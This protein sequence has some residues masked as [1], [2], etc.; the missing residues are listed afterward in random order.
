[1]KLRVDLSST[2]SLIGSVLKWL[3]LPLLA[4]LILSI[5]HGTI[6]APF[7]FTIIMTLTAGFGLEQLESEPELQIRE[8]FLVVSLSWLLIAIVGAL[9]FYLSGTGTLASPINAFF[10]S[11]S[12]FTTT[13]S[14]IL[15]E[16]SERVHSR[17]LLLW[18]Q[19]IQWL[20]GMGIIVLAIAILP[21]LSIGGAQMMNAEAPGPD[22]ERLAPRIAQ[23]ARYLWGVYVILTL[24]EIILLYSLHLL[25]YAP[26]MHLFNAVSHGLTTMP[27][28]GFSPEARS[29]EAFSPLVQWTIIPFMLFAGTNFALLWKTFSGKL[30][31]L[32]TDQE[33]HFYLTILLVIS[34]GF[35]AV[36]YFQNAGYHVEKAL[37]HGIFQTLTIVTTTGYASADFNQWSQMAQTLI[38]LG[39]FIGGCAGST[40]GGI[41]IVRWYVS[42]K[43]FFRELFL[44]LH[45][46]AVRP[47]RVGNSLLSETIVRQ[48]MVF[49]LSYF[50]IF[51]SGSI[52]I[53]L[54]ALRTGIQLGPMA[55]MTS[56]AA[57][58]GNIGPGLAEVGPMS[59]FTFFSPFSKLFLAFLMWLGRLEIMTVLVLIL[60]SYWR[61]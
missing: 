31:R 20:G 30:Q 13:G 57:C 11:M 15:E 1:M 24:C 18:R 7:L 43:V 54:D 35:S 42:V 6:S 56:V 59:N 12:G 33:F 58:I 10:E 37:R 5:V 22:I 52:I 29:I 36:L 32:W 25:G 53:Y 3:A 44:T 26:K 14:T 38:F 46:G 51:L 48:V 28:G 47:V 19:I 23:T 34:W 45:P 17:P 27:T 61:K 55:V 4:P 2:F 8:A 50:M 49:V 40:G 21:K 60:P 16:I 41:K 39:M 9:P